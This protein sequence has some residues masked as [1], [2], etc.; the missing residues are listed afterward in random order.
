[1]QRNRT[2]DRVENT[3]KAMRDHCT[4]I[5]EDKFPDTITYFYSIQKLQYFISDKKIFTCQNRDSNILEI[6]V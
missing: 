3:L 2:K 5:I 1:M 6:P 4:L